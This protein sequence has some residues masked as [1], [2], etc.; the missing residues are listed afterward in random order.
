MK[1]LE[2]QKSTFLMDKDYYL[3]KQF[4]KFHL[5]GGAKISGPEFLLAN[6]ANE[7]QVSL[8]I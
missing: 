5:M 3:M 4:W 1:I 8:M 2:S 6:V 7:F